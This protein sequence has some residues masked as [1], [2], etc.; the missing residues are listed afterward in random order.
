MKVEGKTR[1]VMALFA[2]AVL[3]LL[4]SRFML[5]TDIQVIVEGQSTYIRVVPSVY[6]AL[7]CVIIAISSFLLGVSAFYLF[8]TYSV[9]PGKEKSER[10]AEPGGTGSAGI[11]V[12]GAGC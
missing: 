6:T 8:I 1:L 7:D 5:P 11:G 2:G 9:M 3:M 4:A 10:K 12:T